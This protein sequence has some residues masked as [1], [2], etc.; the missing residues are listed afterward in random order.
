MIVKDLIDPQPVATSIPDAPWYVML[1]EPQQDLTTVWRL[2]ELGLE[3][4]VP[5]LRRRVKTGRLGKN[6]HKVTRVIA[7]PMFPG[8]GFLRY[9]APLSSVLATRGVRDFMRNEEGKPVILPNSAV[10]SVYRRQMQEHYEFLKR[11]QFKRGERVRIDADGGV[12]AGLVATVDE[13]DSKGRIQVLFGMI[14]H[15]LRA[16]MVVAA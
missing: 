6:G 12:Y 7:K 13:V 16:D 2:H 14:R 1:T 8:Y 3:M 5:V 15:T 10:Q 9:G 4:F 11:S